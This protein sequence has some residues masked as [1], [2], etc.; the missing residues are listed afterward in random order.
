MN[1]RTRE[2]RNIGYK[3]TQDQ[4]KWTLKRIPKPPP[5]ASPVANTAISTPSSQEIAGKQ[6][7]QEAHS[8]NEQGVQYCKDK[9]WQKAVDA[10]EAALDKNPDDKTIR[11]NY[12]Q[13]VAALAAESAE[14]RST[15]IPPVGPAGTVPSA[16][17]GGHTALDQAHTSDKETRQGLASGKL[18][19]MKE[20]SNKVF[21]NPVPLQSSGINPAVDL[22]NVGK[23]PELPAFVRND[24]E[25]IQMQRDRDAFLATQQK[26]DAELTNIRKQIE[27][28]PD[29]AKKGDLMVKAAQ[30]KAD[31]SQAEYDAALK[32]KE[33]QKRAKLLIDTHVENPSPPS[34]DQNTPPPDSPKTVP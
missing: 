4:Y 3:V 10:F 27:A 33:I 15:P 1:T 22:R 5:P 7:Q 14:S 2:V 8:L 12:K 28:E 13:A 31:S 9:Q 20:Q 17:A 24:K 21:D 30:I 26:R 6:R 25:I 16:G 11:D 29:L 32:D 18:E 23:A 19:K 34:G